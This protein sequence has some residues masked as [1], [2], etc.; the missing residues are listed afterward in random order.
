MS[1]IRAGTISDAAGTGPITLT[2]QSASKAWAVLSGDATLQDSFNISSAVDNSSGNYT[3]SFTTGFSNNT[4][5][6]PS[7][8]QNGV[9]KS[10]TVTNLTTSS[11][12]LLCFGQSG[13]AGGSTVHSVAFGDLA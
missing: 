2:G 8:A 4:Y 11:F 5:P 13:G 12:V 6:T 1:D 9:D 3:L 10:V 7:I